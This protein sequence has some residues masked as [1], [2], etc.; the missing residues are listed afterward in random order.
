MAGAIKHKFQSTVVDENVAGEVG[1]SEWNDRLAVSEGNDGEVM[2]RRTAAS[3]GWELIPLGSR[4]SDV[5][6]TTVGNSGAGE[7]DLH[8]RTIAAGHFSTNGRAVQLEGWGDFAANATAKT[9]RFKIGGTTFVL[10]PNSLTP[11]ALRWYVKIT[12]TRTGASA[13][14]A[15]A[16]TFFQGGAAVGVVESLLNATPAENTANAIVVKWTGQ[17]GANND[18]RQLGSLI[19]YL[20]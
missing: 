2:V 6:I 20:G 10:N 16:E 17:G 9:L 12:I 15:F 19:S 7:T 5:N 14:L 1:P 18:I 8:S 4:P 3:D 11:N 13:Q